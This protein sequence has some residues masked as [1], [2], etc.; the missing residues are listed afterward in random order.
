MSPR[1][2][3]LTRLLVEELTRH[4]P[5]LAQT[6]ALTLA[7]RSLPALKGSASLAGARD[8]AQALSRLERRFVGGDPTALASA[9]RLAVAARDALATGAPVPIAVWPEPP[10]DLA[11]RDPKNVDPRYEAEMRDRLE[12]LDAALAGAESDR[13]A[14]A[15]AYR[16]V[17][18]MKGAALAVGDEATAWFCH[19]LEESLRAAAPSD[20]DATS[21]LADLG[22]FRL[23]LGE[24]VAAPDRAIAALRS[25]ARPS[26]PPPPSSI[27]P[28]RRKRQHTPFDAE[29]R[30]AADDSLRVATV[31]LDR[32]LERVRQIGQ[33]RAHV[34]AGSR[35]SKSQAITVRQLRL[36]L[37]EA[38]RLIGPPRPWGA[39]AAA[40]TRIEDAAAA[41]GALS[42]R[43]EEESDVLKETS[44]RIRA[45]A[46]AS[47]AELAE[48]RPTRAS[49]LFE[50]VSAA[51][52]KPTRGDKV[53]RS[54][55]RSSARI[56][57]WIA[58]SP[59]SS[60]IRCC[61]S[62]GTPSRTAWRPPPSAPSAASRASR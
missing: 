39:P 48:I 38:L 36:G 61:S 62:R 33:A 59:S 56:P 18:A 51:T 16:E 17:H 40:I 47:L 24:L 6:A 10:L 60:S 53:A 57:R 37:S 23:V 42:E 21:A 5:D 12:R 54:A 7:R 45:E 3:E 30:G 2:P 41:L 35:L 19:G 1:D 32:L 43:L 28:R 34:T 8:L 15:G 26:L 11:T 29:V 4:E 55:S 31:T 50:R 14:A 27:D 52:L 46:G 49:W 22:R 44:E 13:E 20:V 58:A 25:V 9:H